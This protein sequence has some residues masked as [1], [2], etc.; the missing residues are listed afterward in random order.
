MNECRTDVVSR[1]I[2]DGVLYGYTRC[3]DANALDIDVT[4]HELKVHDDCD[5]ITAGDWVVGF[6]AG[7]Q[8]MRERIS[9]PQLMFPNEHEAVDIDTGETL[10]IRLSHKLTDVGP[11]E[12][13]V[14]GAS[15]FDCDANGIFTLFIPTPGSV[16]SS[17]LSLFTPRRF[18][19]SG[20]EEIT[21]VSGSIDMLGDAVIEL[22]PGQWQHGGIFEVP[23]QTPFDSACF[24][25][26]GIS[27]PGG[28]FGP[29]AYTAV[30]EVKTT[31]RPR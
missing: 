18:D 27:E 25:G 3:D 5:N 10:P 30:I 24:S 12:S 1:D 15:A 20:E 21:E 26:G 31:R 14:A 7:T 22:L 19:C 17:G 11:A 6:I 23:A 8:A 4:L 29:P 2:N 16:A 9:L 28:R 13:I